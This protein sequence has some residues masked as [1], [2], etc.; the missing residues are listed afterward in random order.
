[1]GKEPKKDFNAHDSFFILVT[2]SHILAAAMEVLGMDSLDDD[3]CEQLIPGDVDCLSKSERREILTHIANVIVHS[4]VDLHH[5]VEDP[6]VTE[7]PHEDSSKSEDSTKDEDSSECEEDS[8][9]G[10]EDC[11]K[12]GDTKQD[13]DTSD[14]N[15]QAYARE[16]LTLG[17]IYSEFADGIREGDGD[18]VIR[19]WK[20]LMLIF[21]ATQRKNYSCEAFALL[22]QL[23]FILSPR[24]LKCSL[25][26]NTQGGKRKN[27]PCDLH[28]EHLNRVIK[29]GIKGLGANNRQSDNQAWKVHRYIQSDFNQLR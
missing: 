27:I 25:F 5:S 22:A 24:L 15:V 23:E 10:E 2:T 21:K 9:E 8:R 18:R 28:M 6:V 7:D 19:C 12:G 11:S 14:D 13:I 4:Y 29:D 1:M 20:F 3:P 17:L 26:I 16:V